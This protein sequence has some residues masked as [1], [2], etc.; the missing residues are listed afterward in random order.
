[1]LGTRFL[2]G[3]L[4]RGSRR[5]ASRHHERRRSFEQ[6]CSLVE[7]GG[8]ALPP[9]DD[10]ESRR[11]ERREGSRGFA[12]RRYSP[13]RTAP[14][15]PHIERIERAGDG[16]TPYDTS[17]R[18]EARTETCLPRPPEPPERQRLQVQ[19]PA[20]GR[21]AGEQHLEA[22]VER[23]PV[24]DPGADATA[25]PLV[26]LKQFDRGAG[27]RQASCRDQAGEPST[28]DDDVHA[29]RFGRPGQTRFRPRLAAIRGVVRCS[30]ASCSLDSFD[31]WPRR[32][33]S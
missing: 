23:E 15:R 25:D 6:L 21:I 2:P 32:C 10:S 24:D 5:F 8:S 30:S 27:R 16:K 17:N 26:G 18:R 1:M 28:G 13:P 14:S 20:G 4:V 31:M 19:L 7:A 22:A 3:L 29:R 11:I 9:A 33:S 12:S